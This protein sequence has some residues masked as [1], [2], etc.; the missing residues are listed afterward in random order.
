MLWQQSFFISRSNFVQPIFNSL[1]LH[2]AKSCGFFTMKFRYDIN[3]LRALAV[4][5]VVFYHFN[6]PYFNGGYSGVDIFFVISG[7]LMSKIIINKLNNNDLNFIEF[8]NK[9]A[10]R[11]IPALVTMVTLVTILGNVFFFPDM[12]KKISEFASSSLLFLSNIYYYFNSGYFDL[13]SKSNPFLHTWS[14]SVEWQ[15][16]I[17]YPILL[18][19]ISKIISPNKKGFQWS[20][21][22]LLLGSI[23][24]S[25]YLGKSDS[26][27]AFYSIFTRAWEML[28]GCLIVLNEKTIVS[29]IGSNIRKIATLFSFIFLFGFSAVYDD[30]L[31]WPSYYT[32]IPVICTSIILL[33]NTS[34][35]LFENK[36]LQYFGK[37]SY[38]LYLWHWPLYVFFL[39]WGFSALE[40]MPIL[41]ALSVL[42]ADISYRII[43]TK[44]QPKIKTIVAVSCAALCF[45]IVSVKFP[46]NAFLIPDNIKTLSNYRHNNEKEIENQFKSGECFIFSNSKYSDFNKETCL[47]INPNK[48]NVLLLGDSHA[49]QYSYSLNKL[50]NNHD[51]N[52]LQA[53]TSHC[54]PVPNTKGHAE[55]VKLMHYIFNE[56]LPENKNKINLVIISANWKDMQGYKQYE[57]EKKWG[58]LMEY[59]E[60]NNI[61][62]LIL[63]QTETYNYPFPEIM[64][65]KAMFSIVNVESFIEKTSSKMNHRLKTVIPKDKYID[66]YRLKNS[67][68][69]SEDEKTPYMVDDNHFSIFGTEQ[70]INYI[71][72]PILNSLN[73]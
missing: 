63:G 57:L 20:I 22:A 6:I 69:I 34:F 49:A 17:L 66:L 71:K 4:L 38:S 43:E 51:A 50:L 2:A 16:Y 56:F 61:N 28:I 68:L 62:Y 31:L 44:F 33:S 70:V 14:L 18:W 26:S 10:F 8:Y 58:E 1:I 59:F 60:K 3:A 52:L 23:V 72:T 15:F 46:L 36:L 12:E 32:L 5:L 13:S 35:T 21:V 39:T 73:Y 40:Y 27:Q 64:A 65:K 48:K 42:L 54:F 37:I 41:F 45:A 29:K 11:I 30:T 55:N 67:H 25:I 9:R 53:T 19:G 24:Y 7:Y 47:N